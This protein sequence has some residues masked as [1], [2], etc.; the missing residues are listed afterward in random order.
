[1]FVFLRGLRVF[2]FLF[3]MRAKYIYT[4]IFGPQ[5]CTVRLFVIALFFLFTAVVARGRHIIFNTIYAG[6]DAQI[7]TCTAS[8]VR[9]KQKTIRGAQNVRMDMQQQQYCCS[10]I[11]DIYIFLR[12]AVYGVVQVL[13]HDSL[14]IYTVALCE[15]VGRVDARHEK[16]IMARKR[17]QDFFQR[18]RR[19]VIESE[20]S[21]N[22]MCCT[23]C[24]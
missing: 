3:C 1:M 16:T 4:Y 5:K 7:S 13:W 21:N 12:S 15:L 11:Q 18:P 8:D 10:K 17:V 22:M 24:S 2:F 9:R 20:E 19:D 14:R 6:G 23:V